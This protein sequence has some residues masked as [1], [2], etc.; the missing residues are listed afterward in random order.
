[1]FWGIGRDGHGRNELGKAL[2]S[3]KVA[4]YWLIIVILIFL[5]IR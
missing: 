2:G 3:F 1:V 4:T 5:L